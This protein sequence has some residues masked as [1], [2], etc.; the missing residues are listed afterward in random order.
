MQAFHIPV[1]LNESIAHLN[2]KSNGVYVDCTLG[3][4]GHSKEILKHLSK[5]GMLIS[6]DQDSEAIEFVKSENEQLLK[7]TNWKLIHSNFKD[8]QKIDLL[9]NK[10]VDG[11]LMD[12]GVSSRQ[13]DQANRGFTYSNEQ[14]PLDMR[15]NQDLSVSAYDLIQVLNEKELEKLFR[16]YGEE[17]FA[18][19]IAH[20][21][22]KTDI[23]NVGDLTSLVYKVV[24]ATVRREDSHHPARRV[25]QALRIAVNDEINSLKD[26]LDNAFEVLNK[27]GRLVVITF[28]SLEDRIVKDFFKSKEKENQAEIIGDYIAPTEEEINLNSRSRTAKLRTLEK[29]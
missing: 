8:I 11:I 1:L 4:A 25:F 10:K 16:I 20:E 14:A 24:P 22:K 5:D 23:K 13:L 6:I 27:E 29:K 3:E 12:L 18:R 19:K 2:I 17:K 9:K 26:G 28:Q 7:E 21:I 15:M